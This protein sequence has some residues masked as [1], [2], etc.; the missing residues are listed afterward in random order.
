MSDEQISDRLTEIGEALRRQPSARDE[1]L[2]RIA[3]AP[4]PVQ[5]RR[6]SSF[7]R[8]FWRG[9]AALAACLIVAFALTR[10]PGG[11]DRASEAFAAA[12]D[13]VAKAHTFSCRQISQ[14]MGNDGKLQIHETTYWFKEP[15]KSRLQHGEWIGNQTMITDYGKH[16][17]L[18]L[19]PKDKVAD[20]QD[21]SETYRV[22]RETGDL[23]PAKLETDVRDDVMKLTAEAVKDLG[24][25]ERD[26]RKVRVLQSHGKESVRTV[27]VNPE[28]RQ[29]V[30]IVIEWPKNPQSKFT[31]TDIRIDQ[32]LDDKLF[33]LDVPAGYKLFK[34]GP[35]VPA[36]AYYSKMM[37]KMRNL[38]MA[39]IEYAGDH[40]GEFPAKLEQ[41]VGSNGMTAEKLAKLVSSPDK[42]NAPPAI[43]YRRPRAGKD[44]GTEIILYEAPEQRRDGKVAAG[45][46][47]GHAQ[48]MTQ[49]EFEKLMK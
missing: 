39:C 15:D 32:E 44:G 24:M 6:P 14:E 46:T 5:I 2:K 7:A 30:E 12:I 4:A 36:Q 23:E 38:G 33:S 3:R 43:L 35:Y 25:Q 34:G 45:F 16:R 19:I 47:D 48:I 27:Y 20:L 9:F 17:R 37:T 1:V 41:L 28:T 42:P 8:R 11:G 18:T 49:A 13:Q 40:K 31:Y 10:L 29:P 22:N 21:T 26:G